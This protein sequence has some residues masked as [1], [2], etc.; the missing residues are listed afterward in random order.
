VEENNGENN[1]NNGDVPS[2]KRYLLTIYGGNIP[3]TKKV[4]NQG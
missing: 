3:K 1:V 4:R 2:T